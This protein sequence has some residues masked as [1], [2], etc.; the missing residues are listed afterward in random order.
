MPRIR[1]PITLGPDILVLFFAQIRVPMAKLLSEFRPQPRLSG[2][3]GS[4]EKAEVCWKPFYS[5]HSTVMVSLRSSGL[6]KKK[7]DFFDLVFGRRFSP[8]FR[9]SSFESGAELCPSTAGLAG[10]LA[11]CQKASETLHQIQEQWEDGKAL[12]AGQT[13]TALSYKSLVV[14]RV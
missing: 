8:V 7:S 1:D 5:H 6:A 11:Q 4:P 9:G 3:C 14:V 13:G 10:T 12:T 2:L